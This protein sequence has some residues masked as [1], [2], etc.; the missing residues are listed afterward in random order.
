MNFTWID[1]GMTAVIVLSTVISI[2]RG[3]FKEIL[4]F[5]AWVIA[6]IL[7]FMFSEILANMLIEYIDKPSLRMFIARSFIFIAVLIV[8]G[9]VNRIV[10]S[11]IDVTGLSVVNRVLGAVFGGMRGF[12]LVFILLELIILSPLKQESAWEKSELLP[13]VLKSQ[14]FCKNTVVDLI[15][16]LHQ[17][18]G[19]IDS[20]LIEEPSSK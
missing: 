12:L 13:H 15:G 3:F 1:W 5:F 18:G 17:N 16:Q 19:F 11:F 6:V 8:V 7:A 14:V 9:L 20:L 2:N 4:S 10:T